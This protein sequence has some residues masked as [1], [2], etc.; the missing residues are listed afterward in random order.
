MVMQEQRERSVPSPRE[1]DDAYPYKQLT[2]LA[3]CRLA[4]PIAFCS[5][6]AYTF[7]M[8]EDIKGSEDASFYAGLLV[9]AFAMAEASTAMIWGRISD[10]YGRKPIVLFGLVGV[11]LSSLIFGFAKKYWV[12]LLA[13][14]VGGLLNGNVAVMQTMVAEMVKRPEHEPSAY[15]VQPFV[16]SLGSIAGS[17]LGG[18]LAQPARFYPHI[19]SPDG[20]FGQYPYL[21]PN[22]VCVVVIIIAIIQGIMFLEETNPM[23][24]APSRAP[25]RSASAVQLP[26]NRFASNDETTSLL[27]PRRRR[28]SAG[29]IYSTGPGGVSYVAESMPMPL[30]PAF[31]LRRGSL[32]SI[33]SFPLRHKPSLL[34]RPPLPRIDTG[35]PV[36]SAIDDDDMDETTKPESFKVFNKGVIMW[37]I[38]LVFQSYHSMGFYSLLPVYLLDDA[39]RGPRQLDLT[40]GLGMTLHEVGVYLAIGSVMSLFFQGVIFTIF[41]AKLGVWKSVLSVT[42][43]SPV[44]Y[45]LVPFLSLLGNPGAGVYGIL[46]LSSFANV[47]AFPAFLILLKNATP[48]PL[49]LGQVNGLAMSACSAAR[50]VAPPLIG[51]F[52]SSL[53]S[54]GA[55]WSNAFFATIGIVQ[56]LFAPRPKNNEEE[57]IPEAIKYRISYSKRSCNLLEHKRPLSKMDFQDLTNMSHDGPRPAAFGDVKNFALSEVITLY[58]GPDRKQYQVHKDLL[59]STSDFFRACLSSGM[60]ESQKNEVALPEDTTEEFDLIIPFLYT[61]DLGYLEALNNGYALLSDLATAAPDKEHLIRDCIRLYTTGAKYGIHKLQDGVIDCLIRHLQTALIYPH[62]LKWSFETLGKES[63]LTR[64]LQDAL[65]SNMVD[66]PQTYD[67]SHEEHSNDAER[68]AAES[69]EDSLKE[70]LT[71]TDLSLSLTRRL[72]SGCVRGPLISMM[73]NPCCFHMHKAGDDCI[74][75]L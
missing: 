4:E 19:F 62:T 68:A 49:V 60:V 75:R 40:G 67:T 22:L 54:S 7:V 46:A 3:L 73:D 64:L 23:S 61:Q 8:V 63:P 10:K 18:F 55:W 70:M 69:Y 21:L 44:I 39:R 11:A 30:D 33:G 74:S 29:S 26:R 53:G 65:I 51:I 2:V 36:D 20:I 14:V 9:S 48:S 59:M 34:A 5:I 12:A 56:F 37:T 57:I 32:S 27:R 41:V 17:A 52:Y 43:L 6:T 31:D 16:W 25:S 42:V 50:T 35:I 58:V 13:R 47:I 1:G 38:A 72:A 66:S 71:N 28:E 15:A 45:I 24:P